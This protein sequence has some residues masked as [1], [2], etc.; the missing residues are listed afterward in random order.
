MIIVSN[1][2]NQKIVQ[3]LKS[4]LACIPPY[5][6]KISRGPIFVVITDDH[7]TTKIKPTK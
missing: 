5:S 7:L 1:D 2:L 6:R 4:F 3:D